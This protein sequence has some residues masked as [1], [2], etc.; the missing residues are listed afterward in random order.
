MVKLLLMSVHFKKK[1]LYEP[2][3]KPDFTNLF[4][5]CNDFASGFSGLLSWCSW[6]C[7]KLPLFYL[8]MSIA[9]IQFKILITHICVNFKHGNKLLCWHLNCL[10][11]PQHPGK[12]LNFLWI[13]CTFLHKCP[14]NPT[15][16]YHYLIGKCYSAK[17]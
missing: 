8:F 2:K 4:G 9:F 1:R 17:K 11:S 13:Y 5:Y 10:K 7:H 15:M 16:F 12:S 14:T 3:K 6:K